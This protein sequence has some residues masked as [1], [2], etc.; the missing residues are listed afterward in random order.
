M[1]EIGATNVHLF[2][3]LGGPYWVDSNGDGTIN[4]SDTPASTGAT[5]LALDNVSF[6]LALLRPTAAG[7][8]RSYYALSASADSI[9]LV[10]VPGLT[11]QAT[12][13]SR[14]TSTAR[15]TARPRRPLFSR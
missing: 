8:T 11:L 7:S 2:V 10:G 5:G 9:A 13:M 12:T 4:A 1:L 14:S 15:A 6:A 3:G